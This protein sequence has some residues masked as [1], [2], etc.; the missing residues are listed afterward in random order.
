MN[1]YTCGYIPT[2]S[3][4]FLYEIAMKSD[5]IEKNLIKKTNTIPK[6]LISEVLS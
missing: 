1:S 5:F 3:F 6:F 2:K 4:Q